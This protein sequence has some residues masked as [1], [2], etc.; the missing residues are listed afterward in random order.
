VVAIRLLD[1][2]AA[3]V[4]VLNTSWGVG[5]IA[6]GAVAMML[7]GR[8]RLMDGLAGGSVAVSMA[9]AVVGLRPSLAIAVLSLSALGAGYAV[10]EVAGRT[11]MQ[12]LAGDEVLARAFAVIESSYWLASGAGAIAVPGLVAVLGTRGALFAM[13][14]LV[15]VVAV[16]WRALAGVEAGIAVAPREFGLLRRLELFAAV[17]IAT[18]ETLALRAVPVALAPGDVVIREGEPGDC[19]YVV[20]D[21]D[22]TIDRAS[23]RCAGAGPGDFFGE[24]ALLRSCPR[25]ASVTAKGPVLLLALGR[26]DFLEA[27][28]GHPRAEQAARRAIA[29]R[30]QPHLGPPGGAS[31]RG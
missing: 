1:L 15:G 29:G 19:F 24:T 28:T 10:V 12:R 4:G 30:L 31:A 20:A 3:G 16:S 26:E 18:V 22:L 21:G 8:G 7:L 14:A 9:L 17:P 25:T 23:S 6:G 11:L 13:S 27:V 2:G 5:G